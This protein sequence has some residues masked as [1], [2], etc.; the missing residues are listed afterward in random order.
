MNS[1]N[2][3]TQSYKSHF[4]KNDKQG[5]KK[6]NNYKSSSGQK[7]KS[8]REQSGN[9]IKTYSQPRFLKEE[10]EEDSHL[11]G[12]RS[13]KR[14]EKEKPLVIYTEAELYQFAKQDRRERREINR[15]KNKERRNLRKGW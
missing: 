2:N 15:Q 9:K 3:K 6:R 14:E 10:I 5:E 11:K 7:N 12:R 8:Y 13:H 1:N 4:N